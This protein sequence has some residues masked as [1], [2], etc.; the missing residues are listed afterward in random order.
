MSVDFK[1]TKRHYIQKIETLKRY[2]VHE[3]HTIINHERW[4]G[5]VR[6][7]VYPEV[8]E[9]SHLRHGVAQLLEALCYK[10]EGRGVESR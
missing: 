5:R 8:L 2:F 7:Q 4:K 3:N 9:P 10:P 6:A 1:Q